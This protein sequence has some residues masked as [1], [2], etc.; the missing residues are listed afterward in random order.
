VIGLKTTLPEEFGDFPPRPVLVAKRP[1]GFC[2]IGKIGSL[3][4]TDSIR[5]N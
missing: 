1:N 4:G 5:E 3:W 2:V